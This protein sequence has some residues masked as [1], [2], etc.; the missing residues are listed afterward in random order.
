MRGK[1]CGRMRGQRV[2]GPRGWPGGSP[3]G[4]GWR[5]GTLPGNV[6]ISSGRIGASLPIFDGHRIRNGKP[7][8]RRMYGRTRGMRVPGTRSGI[9]GPGRGTRGSDR[10]GSVRLGLGRGFARRM[11]RQRR[12]GPRDG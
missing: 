1:S 6:R 8:G 5:G 3:V 7:M 12:D 11:R 4:G 2:R 9:E 10:F